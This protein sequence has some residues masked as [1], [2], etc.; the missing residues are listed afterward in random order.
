MNTLVCLAIYTI[1]CVHFLCSD[2]YEKII[3]ITDLRDYNSKFEL[4]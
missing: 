4:L 2:N 1:I 3:P